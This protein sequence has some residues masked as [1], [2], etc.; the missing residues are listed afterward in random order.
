[1]KVDDIF[2]PRGGTLQVAVRTLLGIH[3]TTIGQLIGQ[4]TPTVARVLG[5]HTSH[6]LFNFLH[7]DFATE[8]G[9][10]SEVSS[11]SWIGSSHHVLGIKHLLSELRNTQGTELVASTRCQGSETNHEEVQ[12]REGDHVDCKFSEIRVELTGEAETGGDARHDGRDKMVKISICGSIEFKSTNADIVQ[13]FIV[14]TE[15]LIG[16]LDELL[17]VNTALKG[18]YVDG[19]GGV[20]RF[21]DSIGDLWRWNDGKC[22]HH[23]IGVFFAN[24]ADQESTHTSTGTSAERVCYLETLETVTSLGFASN[25]IQNLVN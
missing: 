1:M 22:C 9:C 4:R 7:A 19:E 6:L 17:H 3:S 11:L 24:F 2:N 18:V 16:V 5:L 10:D 25:N 15:G 13:G 12:T 8:D 23:S 20:I 14:N 21:D